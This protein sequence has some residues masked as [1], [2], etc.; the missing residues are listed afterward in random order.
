MHLQ[1]NLRGTRTNTTAR[2]LRASGA[3]RNCLV[4]SFPFPTC[5]S[6]GDSPLL[7]LGSRVSVSYISHSGWLVEEWW[8]G[9]GVFVCVF[10][11]GGEVVV[12]MLEI[13]RRRT[14]IREKSLSR[15]AKARWFKR[16]SKPRMFGTLVRNS[17]ELLNMALSME[18]SGWIKS[19]MRDEG[20]EREGERPLK[21]G[22]CRV[23]GGGGSL[24]C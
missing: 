7:L 17:S 24:R 3:F 19:R 23:D 8:T 12:D 6:S 4:M 18:E 13:C 21:G 5:T 1:P 11:C 2:P 22:V 14:H 20:E 16:P 10:I 15:A 9:G